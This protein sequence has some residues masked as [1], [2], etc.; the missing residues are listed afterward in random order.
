MKLKEFTNISNGI[1]TI[2]LYKH[3]GY[4]G[5]LGSGI[6]GSEFANELQ[7]YADNE[8]VTEIN[9]RINSPGGTVSDGYSILASILNCSKPVNT[10]NDGMAYS[11]AGVILTAGGKSCMADYAT[12]MMH[13]A[14]GE[15]DQPILNLISASLSKIFQNRT[16]KSSEDVEGMMKT[17]TWLNAQQCKEMGFVDEVISSSKKIKAPKTKNFNEL[18]N[19]YNSI[20]TKKTMNK[21]T[22]YLKISNES[23]E[24]AVLAAFSDIA[25][26]SNEK[27]ESLEA[28]LKVYQDLEEAAK[29]AAKEAELE[30]FEIA[31]TNAIKEGKV[32]EA[33]KEDFKTLAISNFASFKTILNSIPMPIKGAVK[34]MDAVLNSIKLEGRDAWTIRDWEKNDSKGLAEILKNN[35]VKYQE[36][37]N[38]YYKKQN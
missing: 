26:E 5:H 27:I 3:I 31:I 29:V 37:Y 32:L 15:S 2:N 11:I 7:Y 23:D 25:K 28:Q 34:I 1:A 6:I 13:D 18:H 17:E 10:F 22:D 8:N 38:S 19:F 35:P 9:V 12:F 16:G 36:M 21:L 24:D 33:S 14:Q 30:E 4:D 20:L